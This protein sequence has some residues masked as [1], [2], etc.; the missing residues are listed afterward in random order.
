MFSKEAGMSQSLNV[1]TIGFYALLAVG[2]AAAIYHI[3]SGRIGNGI[4]AFSS[5]LVGFFI[6]REIMNNPPEPAP[7][8]ER[9][10]SNATSI[11]QQLHD[12]PPNRAGIFTNSVVAGFCA[13]IV[14]A[15]TFIVGFAFTGAFA[16]ENGNILA[17]WFYGLTNNSLTDSAWDIPLAAYSINLFAS[18]IWAV[19]YGFVVQPRLSGPGWQRGMTFSLAPWLLSLVGFFPLVGAGVFGIDLD[20]GPLPALG[21]LIL[22]L[23]YGAVLGTVYAMPERAFTDA[24]EASDTEVD[25]QNQGIVVGL[26]GGLAVGII[27]GSAAAIF[28]PNSFATST[29][30]L[31]AGAATGVLFGGMAGPLIGLSTG[32]EQDMDTTPPATVGP[33]TGVRSH[34]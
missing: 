15:L 18:L 7:A 19:I 30:M 21:N 4:L 1:R 27:A 20:A 6:Q 10:R 25:R 23:V 8:R 24:A 12:A 28:V 22:H 26:V 3:S 2:I 16:N 11:R 5:V 31:L 14:M 32:N 13:M 34:P 29:E 9:T 33:Q 17:R